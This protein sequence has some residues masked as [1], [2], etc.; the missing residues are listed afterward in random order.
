M[1]HRRSLLAG[2]AAS[3]LISKDAAARLGS[4]TSRGRNLPGPPFFMKAVWTQPS[5]MFSTWSSRG[6][7]V[8]NLVP[9]GWDP[10]AWTISAASGGLRI[11]K[12]ANAPPNDDT[13]IDNLLAWSM[14]D[15]PDDVT[16]LWLTYGQVRNNPE[17]I[18]AMA[19][20]LVAASGTIPIIC[21]LVGNHLTNRNQAPIVLDYL[22]SPQ[23]D[24]WSSDSYQVQDGR[25]FLLTWN[26]Y[27]STHQGYALDLMSS[28]DGAVPMS[29]T[30]PKIQFIGTSDFSSTGRTPTPGQ[31]RAMAWSTIIH[32]AFG[33]IYFPIVLK[34]TFA[35][36]GTPSNVVSEMKTLHSVVDSIADILIDSGHGGR[37]P[38]TLRRCANNNSSPIGL[39]LPYPF[40]GCEIVTSR[41]VYK[42]VLNLVD[43]VAT[44]TDSRWGLSGL[45]FNAYEVKH[46]Y[47]LH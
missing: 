13:R 10:S 30:K 5:S 40:E 42:I 17:T 25:S 32:G 4:D 22:N 41:G 19:A 12:F 36:D 33:L 3:P 26:G 44:L 2:L 21:N 46:G 11:I 38:S 34:P 18:R 16:G 24:W 47:V 27:T 20:P 39:Q 7:N 43:D 37:L 9:Q 14:P 23:I 15:E 28:Y 6:I 1:L 35:W 31:F 8:L 29:A 45:V